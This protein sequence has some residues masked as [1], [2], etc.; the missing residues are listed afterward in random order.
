MKARTA[1]A[2]S[3]EKVVEKSSPSAMER[4]N[5]GTC[6]V[7]GDD[8]DDGV[9]LRACGG[10]GG[11][12]SMDMDMDI[13]MDMDMDTCLHDGGRARALQP[14]DDGGDGDDPDEDAARHLMGARA[15]VSA[16]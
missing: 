14:P 11:K 3:M 8:D 15:A 13:D 6:V 7:W 16:E 2:I 9:E 1:E 5:L 10:R 12:T 4:L